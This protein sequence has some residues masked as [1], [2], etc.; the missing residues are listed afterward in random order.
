MD[1]VDMIK[2]QKA[3]PRLKDF[4]SLFIVITLIA[5][6][7]IVFN[8][9]NE[10]SSSA[11]ENENNV[12]HNAQ[13]ASIGDTVILDFGGDQ[14]IVGTTKQSYDSFIKCLTANDHNGIRQLLN[15]NMILG[16]DNGT[17]GVL[18]S[19]AGVGVKEVRVLDGE[20]AGTTI[21][22]A[23]EAVSGYSNK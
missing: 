15:T 17:R 19:T 21:Y 3:E 23:S 14:V 7:G 18:V 9:T 22:L 16:I 4:M 1:R 20:F 12:Q 11:T 5:G 2:H 8:L 13:H 6:M 10:K